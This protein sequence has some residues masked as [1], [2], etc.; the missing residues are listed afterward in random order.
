MG[1]PLTDIISKDPLFQQLQDN[2]GEKF[3]ELD[4]TNDA[5][6]PITQGTLLTDVDLIAGSTTIAHTRARDKQPTNYIVVKQ[7]A[8]FTVYLVSIDPTNIVLNASGA[9]TVD[10]WV[11]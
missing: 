5:A 3:N 6:S 9:G 11:Y 1:N 2:L 8:H 10:L 4:A 7:D